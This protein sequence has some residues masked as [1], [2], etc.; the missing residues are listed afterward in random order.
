MKVVKYLCIFCALL[1][2]TGCLST[3]QRKEK[4][5]IE[6]ETKTMMLD[7]LENNYNIKSVENV[8]ARYS[9]TGDIANSQFLGTVIGTFQKDRRKYAIIC[10]YN[11]KK[12]Y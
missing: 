8:T 11:E 5:N 7:Y 3:E 9:N 1:M 2:L 10:N 6:K 4:G 12:C